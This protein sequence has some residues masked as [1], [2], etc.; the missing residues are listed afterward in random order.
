MPDIKCYRDG[1]RTCNSECEAYIKE[2]IYVSLFSNMESG[3]KTCCLEL[4]TKVHLASDLFKI[5]S[6]MAEK[7]HSH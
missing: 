7:M 2:G 5:L 6:I 3:R 1:D 4:A